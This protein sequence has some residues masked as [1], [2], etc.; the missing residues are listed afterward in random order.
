MFEIER[1]D[2]QLTAD[3][4]THLN[5]LSSDARELV[6]MGLRSVATAYSSTADGLEGMANR[7]EPRPSPETRELIENRRTLAMVFRNAERMI[8]RP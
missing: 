6:K 5:S 1:T 3:D 7:D 4:I 8:R 2:Y